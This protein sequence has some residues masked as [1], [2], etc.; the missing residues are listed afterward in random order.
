MD[1]GQ[2]LGVESTKTA[3]N[4]D[5]KMTTGIWNADSPTTAKAVIWNGYTQQQI[6]QQQLH[7]ALDSYEHNGIGRELL[8]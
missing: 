5:K 8:G 6:T 1:G 2:K 4:G 7:L 3:E